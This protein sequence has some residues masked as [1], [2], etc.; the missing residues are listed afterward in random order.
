MT[1]Q[2]PEDY[3]DRLEMWST[4]AAEELQDFCDEAQEST[5]DPEGEGELLGTRALLK[6]LDNILNSEP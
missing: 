4:L 6:D 3:I 1:N 5:G 2:T